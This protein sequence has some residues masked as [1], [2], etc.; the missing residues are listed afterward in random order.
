M[1]VVVRESSSVSSLSL[2]SWSSSSSLLALDQS[3]RA[4]FVN[5][6]SDESCAKLFCRKLTQT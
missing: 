4:L 1:R 3:L 6:V 2:L 5:I